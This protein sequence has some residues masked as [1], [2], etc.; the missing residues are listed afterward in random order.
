MDG[1][2]EGR[3]ENTWGFGYLIGKGWW[4]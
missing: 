1:W 2:E 4:I 3:K